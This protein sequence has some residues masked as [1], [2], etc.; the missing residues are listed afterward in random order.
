[1]TSKRYKISDTEFWKKI[2]SDFNNGGGTYQLYSVDDFDNPIQINRLLKS[3][4][5][6][7]SYIGKAL[8]FLDRVIDLKKSLSPDHIS[9]SHECGVRYKNNLRDKFP[10]EKLWIELKTVENIDEAE[11]K[12]LNDYENKFGELP[13]LNRNK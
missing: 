7:I 1:M 9:E 12:L 13:P 5:Q 6:G 4:N 3:D 8:K 10:Y 11:K 2:D